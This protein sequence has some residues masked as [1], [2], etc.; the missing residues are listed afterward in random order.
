VTY[1]SSVL[2]VLV[3]V[4]PFVALAGLVILLNRVEADAGIALTAFGLIVV[5]TGSAIGYFADRLAEPWN[6]G[7]GP[8]AKRRAAPG[9]R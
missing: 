6:Q 5:L 1:T 7:D 3:F 9:A 8:N 2:R 4:V